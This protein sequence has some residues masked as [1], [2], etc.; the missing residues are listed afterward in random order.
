MN[1]NVER[2]C[3]FSDFGVRNCILTM[4]LRSVIA[5]AALLPLL[6]MT[7]RQ[8]MY[9]RGVPRWIATA[10][11]LAMTRLSLSSPLVGAAFALA[12]ALCSGCTSAPLAPAM[13]QVL[14]PSGKLR[15]GLYPGSPT[16]L[17][18]DPASG[19]AKGLGFEL[20]A[21]LARRLGV[22]FEP[23]VFPKNAD[24]L[25]AVKSG[26]VDAS[27]TNE[28]AERMQDMDFSPTLLEVEKG[29]L[30]PAASSMATQ[31]DV[32]RPGTRIGVSQG[33]ST[34][35]E[36]A[37]EFRHAVMVR[38]PTL[39][40]AIAML[41]SGQLEAF[42]TNKAVLFEM[43]DD[44]PGA[45]VLDG[46]WGLEHFAIALPKGRAQA[47]PYLQRFVADMKA[48][49]RVTQAVQRVGLRGTVPPDGR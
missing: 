9:F 40:S 6:A 36:L 47:A 7:A 12:A 27:F 19:S 5:I 16:S 22:P 35:R 38:T 8:S 23:V 20:G 41:A 42:A 11:G 33:S 32:D 10:L 28:T 25:A 49:G 13:A 43:S 24:V 26:Q 44:L 30:V 4:N 39:K 18:G 17:I 1:D 48:Q 45:R 3:E 46:H 21:E 37:G 31:A 34:E 2:H 15:V 14:A 29:Y